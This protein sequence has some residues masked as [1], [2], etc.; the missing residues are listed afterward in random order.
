MIQ[1]ASASDRLVD[2]RLAAARKG[3]RHEFS[4]LTEPYRRE[5]LA[6]CYRILGSLH[7]AEDMVQET[8]LRAWRRLSTFEGRASLRA[9][10]YKIA[11]NAC[12]DALDKRPRRT[13]PAAMYPAADPQQPLLPP[14]AE[15][16][17]LEPYP[18]D[19]LPDADA[20][21]EARYTARESITLAFLA[22][23]QSL[24]PRQR[25]VL[26]LCDVLDWRADEVAELLETTVSAVNS[27]LHRARATLAQRYHAGGLDAADV[28]TADEATRYL[29]DRYVAAWESADVAGLTALL[30]EDATFSMPPVPSWYRGRAA[31]RAAVSAIALGAEAGGRWRMLPVRSNAQPA[32]ACYRRD[33]AG[34]AHRFF[35]IQV[36]RIAGE[37][38]VDAT[39]FLDPT[40]IARFSLPATV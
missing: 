38:I 28:S 35:G 15:P 40:L 13:L 7:D 39:T 27:A 22:A 2:A 24:P 30:R 19:L 36:L 8:M 26:I 9:W 18:D 1:E 3:D 17:W 31:V 25:A 32:F 37:Q 10:L 11:T 5:L 34:G 21:P 16:I 6:H 4:N 14:V 23:L 20:N 29:L 12:L 33:E